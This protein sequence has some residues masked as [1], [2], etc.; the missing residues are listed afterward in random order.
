MS[1][2]LGFGGWVTTARS[3]TTSASSGTIRG[4]LY[5]YVVGL[6]AGTIGW[7]TLGAME[8][9][10]ADIVDAAVICW[11]SEVGIYG[12]EARYCLEAGWLFGDS[13]TRFGHEY[14]EV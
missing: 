6:I 4:S 1:L 11:A 5:A 12:R 10:I 7:T 9:V 2:A 14:Q 8:G 3:L 13:Q